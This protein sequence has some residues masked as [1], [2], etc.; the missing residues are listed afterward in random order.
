MT[1]NPRYLEIWNAG[2]FMQFN[3]GDDGKLNKLPKLSVDTGAGLERFS[4]LMQG[5]D[6]AYET[7]LFTGIISKIKSLGANMDNPDSEKAIKRIADHVRG[8][9]FIGAESV[10]PSNTD[11]GYVLRKL[12]RNSFNDLVWRLN[13]DSSTLMDIIPVVFDEYSDIYPELGDVNKVLSMVN[14]ECILW[15]KVADNTRLA[16][17][18][19]GKR[20]V[21]SAFD[22]YQSEGS[23]L[24]LVKDIASEMGDIDVDYSNFDELFS[25]HQEKSKAGAGQKFKGGLGDHSE[26]T[27]RFHTATH[28]LHQALRDVLGDHVQQM[29]SN[30]TSERLRFDFSHGEKMSEAQIKEVEDIVNEKIKDS[31]TVNHI[32]LS[33]GEAEKTGALHFFADKYGDEVSVYYIG[34]SL[35]TAWSKE[36]CGGPHV[37]NTSEIGS[38]KIIKEE[39]VGKGVRRIKASN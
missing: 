38:F 16:M 11:Q 22:L 12:I 7:D 32:V 8:I 29:G 4:I 3:R 31:L 17:T 10:F 26:I 34:D 25:A 28:L 6:S 1:D 39:S 19:L 23:S 15:K 20:G 24:E 30:I 14:E 9:S 21:V 13:L 33:K 5:V 36:F 35:E 37:K 27:T 2:V 18:R